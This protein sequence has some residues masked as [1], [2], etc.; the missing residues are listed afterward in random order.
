M[1][2]EEQ[3]DNLWQEAEVAGQA[4]R[5][6]REYPAWERRHI[7]R[8]NGMAAVLVAGFLTTAALP[9]FRTDSHKDYQSVYCNRRGYDDAQWASLAAELLKSE[10][11]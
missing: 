1:M 8:R 7:R 11:V 10:N 3:F 2:T 5:L 6:A 4:S 9:L